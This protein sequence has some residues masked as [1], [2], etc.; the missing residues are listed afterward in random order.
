MNEF[1]DI[2][3]KQLIEILQ[4]YPQDAKIGM[5]SYEDGEVYGTDNINICE[6]SEDICEFDYERCDYYLY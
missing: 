4:T 2:T 5:S 6:W 3:I 1:K